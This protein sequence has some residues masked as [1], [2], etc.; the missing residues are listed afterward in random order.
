MY[1]ALLVSVAVG[2]LL[3]YKALLLSITFSA[4][5]AYIM[6]PAVELVEAKWIKSRVAAC[7]VVVILVFGLLSAL[8]GSLVPYLYEEALGL[9]KLVPRAVQGI[10]TKIEPL[11]VIVIERGL[12]KRE[13]I[14]ALLDSV[15]VVDQLVQQAKGTVNKVWQ[16]TPRVLFGVFNMLLVP[17]MCFIILQKSES[18]KKAFLGTVPVA[19]RADFRGYLRRL[20]SSLKSVLKGQVIVASALAFLYMIGLGMVGIKFGIGIGLIAGCFRVVPYFDLVVGITL[21]MIVIVSKGYGIGVT[22]AVCMVFLV[23]QAIDGM[24]ITPRVIGDRTGLHPG[25]VVLSMIAFADWFGFYGVLVA[26]PMLAIFMV[27]VKTFMPYYR[28]TAFFRKA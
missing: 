1:W 23:V 16:F 21:C 24:V 27:T 7:V 17:V 5:L 8:V 13:A 14:E 2:L 25:F 15:G 28:R 10:L 3:F 11:K 20:D 18:I 9:L 4:V 22:V 19:I 6:L 26:V 12:M